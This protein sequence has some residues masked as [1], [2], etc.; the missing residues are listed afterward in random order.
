MFMAS[1]EMFYA[2]EKIFMHYELFKKEREKGKIIFCS[3]GCM[4]ENI[5]SFAA[6][7]E[8]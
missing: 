5:F 7:S 2:W 4:Y 8:K 6:H 1:R 3:F